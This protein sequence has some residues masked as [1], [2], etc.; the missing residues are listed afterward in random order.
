MKRIAFVL[1]LTAFVLVLAAIRPVAAGTTIDVRVNLAPL[2]RAFS[3]PP[4]GR[5]QG[6]LTVS[7]RDWIPLSL[8]IEGDRMF[9]HR[10]GGG[11]GGVIIGSGSSV[12]IAL[13]RNTYDLFGSSPERLRV[14]IRE[15]RTT[16]LSLEPFGFVGNTGLQGVVNDGDRV[17]TGVLFGGGG[18][19]VVIPQPPVVVAPPPPPIIIQRP[20]LRPAPPPHRPPHR[21]PSRPGFGPGPRPQPLPEP[22]PPSRRPGG[23]RDDGW[24]FTF[25]FE[26]R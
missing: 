23:G 3:P 1:G 25:G 6:W 19:T 16:T 10:G 12:T 22:P 18:N 24:G 14:R 20:P 5:R 26:R 4:L 8:R 21:P 15:G 11:F 17:R 13:D 7:N 9:L 2:G